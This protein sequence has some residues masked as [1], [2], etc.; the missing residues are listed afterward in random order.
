MKYKKQYPVYIYTRYIIPCGG[1]VH[2][3]FGCKRHG[4]LCIP[5]SSLVPFPVRTDMHDT[6]TTAARTISYLSVFSHRDAFL[7]QAVS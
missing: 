4:M 6:T 2:G 1:Y 7:L 3:V 5:V